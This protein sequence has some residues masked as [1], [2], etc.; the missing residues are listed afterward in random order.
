MPRRI[1]VGINAAGLHLLAH[2]GQDGQW[3][4]PADGGVMQLLLSARFSEMSERKARR[5]VRRAYIACTCAHTL[6]NTRSSHGAHT[7]CVRSSFFLAFLHCLAPCR[8]HTRTNALCSTF[9]INLHR[10][11]SSSFASRATCSRSAARAGAAARGRGRTAR[12]GRA[13]A[14]GANRGG[15][16]TRSTRR[17]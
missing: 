14:A 17:R 3:C 1:I 9:R 5:K 6:R 4:A 7:P 16:S 2:V 15:T 10:R 13:P 12:A 8:A 11:F